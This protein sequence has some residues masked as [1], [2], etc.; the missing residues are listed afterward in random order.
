MGEAKRRGS[1]DDRQLQSM[2]L[3]ETL[4]KVRVD[5]CLKHELSKDP[6]IQANVRR[7]RAEIMDLKSGAILRWSDLKKT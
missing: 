4:V 1:R 5:Y 6:V 3:R 7:A 2:E